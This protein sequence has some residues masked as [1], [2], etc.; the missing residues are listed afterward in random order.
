MKRINYLK[1][2]KFIVGFIFVLIVCN[3]GTI[4]VKAGTS[5]IKYDVHATNVGWLNGYHEGD[6]GGTTGMGYAMQAIRIYLNGI[7]GNIEYQTHLRDIGWTTFVKNGEVSGTEGQN[8]AMEAIKIRLTGEVAKVYDVYYRVHVQDIGWLDYACNGQIAGSTG[9]G[10]QIEAIQIKLVPKGTNFYTV[11][12]TIIGY[13]IPTGSIRT[14]SDMAGTVSGSINGNNISFTIK[15]I[16]NSGWL[17]IEYLTSSGYKTVFTQGTNFFT[18]LNMGAVTRLGS[19]MTVYSHS[20]LQKKFGTVYGTDKI[21]IVGYSETNTQIIYPIS[22]N[23]YKVGWIKGIY[24]MDT[25]IEAMIPDGCYQIKSAI[26]QNYVL[27]VY[28][29]DNKDGT[30]VQIYNNGMGTNQCFVI[31][32]Q[33]N[34]YYTIAALHSNKLLDVDKD[35]SHNGANIIQCQSNGTGGNNQLWK[36]WKTKDGYYKFQSK[37]SGL[38]LDVSGG[39]AFNENNVQIWEG[40]ETNAQ[41]FVLQGVA[42]EDSST[43]STI[44]KMPLDGVRCTW[45]SYTNWSWGNN[46]GGSGRVYHLGIDIIGTNDNVQATANGTVA[47]CGWNNANGNY[48]VLKHT[49]DG[50]IIYSFYAHLAEITVSKNQTVTQGQKIGVVGNTGSSSAGKHLHFAMMD[51][52]WNG[53]YYGYATY[54]SGNYKKY[55]GVVYYNPVYI[56][57]NQRL[58]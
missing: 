32:R 19:D 27:D 33:E 31:K 1:E 37:S 46:R 16:Y 2:I 7:D 56:I 4:H 24:N 29:A 23:R 45:R 48:V 28:K 13:T 47:A 42:T 52:L 11:E 55:N 8:R 21:M 3:F 41:K 39:N 15:K 30:N 20:D 58:P 53:S 35:A 17:E 22:Q 36:I 49:L 51:T 34:G 38:F 18:N 5:P 43:Q 44:F 26:N 10:L 40:N 25:D 57:E 12:K 9:C 6:I 50:K 14:Y 54:F